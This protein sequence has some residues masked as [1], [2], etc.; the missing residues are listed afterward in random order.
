LNQ[1]NHQYES[2]VFRNC[3]QLKSYGFSAGCF[4]IRLDHHS[5]RAQGVRDTIELARKIKNGRKNRMFYSTLWTVP[6]ST[7]NALSL[8]TLKQ[9]A[10]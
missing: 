1:K 8:A 4:L 6:M 7:D 10:S 9:I 5:H 3:A 2:G